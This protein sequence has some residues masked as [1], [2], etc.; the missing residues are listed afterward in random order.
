MIRRYSM[1][2]DTFRCLSCNSCTVECKRENNVPFGFF[3]TRIDTFEAGKYPDT[4][5]GFKKAACL[6]CGDA[7]CVV[8][9]PTGASYKTE[10]GVTLVDESKCIKCGYCMYA[11]P[12]DARYWHPVSK[13]PDKCTLCIHRLD[14][15]QKPSCAEKCFAVAILF[16]EWEDM[17]IEGERRVASIKKKMPEANLYKGDGLGGLGVMFVLTKSPVFFDLPE[18]PEMPTSIV[19]WQKVIRPLAYI[20]GGATVA[21]LIISFLANLGKEPEAKI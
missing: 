6:H 16:G 2:I 10:S 18:R 14:A 20:A 1:L 21:G 9:C 7:P 15:G 3:R 17:V 12:F 11:C 5:M 13:K 8:V 19:A 4:F